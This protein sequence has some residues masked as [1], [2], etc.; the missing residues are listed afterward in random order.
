M[1]NHGGGITPRCSCGCDLHC[2]MGHWAPFS[3]II[4]CRYR[5]KYTLMTSF[6]GRM[7]RKGK[8]C[9][10]RGE[11]KLNLSN[12]VGC[13]RSERGGAPARHARKVRGLGLPYSPRGASAC[14]V[15]Q[16][17]CINKSTM[18]NFMLPTWHLKKELQKA[19][20]NWFSTA[21]PMW[22]YASWSKNEKLRLKGLKESTG[23]MQVALVHDTKQTSD[24]SKYGLRHIIIS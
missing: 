11:P 12:D 20:H 1:L 7:V 19:G 8:R 9:S 18:A 23:N 17:S 6:S 3:N 15:C 5:P 10:G 2:L 13:A 4:Y 22:A 24:Y 16:F 14:S 21:S